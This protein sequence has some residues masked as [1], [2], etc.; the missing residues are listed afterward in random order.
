M[1]EARLRN[2]VELA[3]ILSGAAVVYGQQPG[4]NLSGIQL[5]LRI[6]SGTPLRLYITKRVWYHK[7][8]IVQARFAEPVWAFDRIVIPPGTSVTGAITDLVPVPKLARAMAM[9]RGDFT[10]L[11]QAKVRFTSA[12]MPDGHPLAIDTESSFGLTSIYD[13]PRAKKGGPPRQ[14]QTKTKPQVESESKSAYAKSFLKQQAIQQVQAQANAR[15]HG[16]FSFVRSP[17]KRE[18]I[19]DYLWSQL[20]YHPQFYRSGTRFDSVLQQPID[21]GKVNMAGSELQKISSPPPPDSIAAIRSLTTVSSVDARVG[22]PIAAVL[23]Q[24]VFS[25]DH[26]MILPEGTRLTGKVTL[27]RPA[28]M[29]HRSGQL[30]FTFTNLALPATGADAP[31]TQLTAQAQLA[32]AETGSGPASVDP[33]GTAKMTESKARFLRPVIASLVA[34]K[35]MDNDTGKPVSAGGNSNFTGQSL[36]GFS[37]F[38]LFGAIAA[39]GPREIGTALGF[40]GLAWSV[41]GTVVSRGKEVVFEKNAAMSIRFGVSGRQ[42]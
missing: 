8:Q 28:R 5:P 4:P 27:A 39:R 18:W 32:A 37:G 23:S 33:E 22:E 26:K 30:R 10:P 17:N 6:D 38:G 36:G 34:L 20:P 12:T 31:A 41:Y 14:T 16:L 9:I 24:P 7:G 19:E 35:S 13:P 25:A 29:F 40:Y 11:K 15:T 3:A 21:F 1:L 42:R 2:V